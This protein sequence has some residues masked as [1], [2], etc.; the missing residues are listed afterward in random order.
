MRKVALRGLVLVVVIGVLGVGS[1]AIAGGGAKHFK[2][3]T[4]DG[5]EENP[6][7]ST[8]RDG[9]RSRRSSRTTA[10]RSSTSS[11][12]S[13][14]EGTVLARARAL[15]QGGVNGGVSCSCA[16]GGD[17]AASARRPTGGT[18]H[19]RGYRRSGRAS[20][21][22]ARAS[23]PVSLAEIVAAM[24]AGHAYANVHSHELARRRDPRADQR[25]QA[26]N[27]YGGAT[28]RRRDRTRGARSRP[29]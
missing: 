24:R 14:L 18:V 5:Y 17:Q 20:G 11:A 29:A 12:Y 6:D 16:S 8:R 26:S 9:R 15:R 3:T 7:V 21:R 4:L 23:L 13:G 25:P 27:D 22:P 19:R 2:G 1:Y 28:A 10:R